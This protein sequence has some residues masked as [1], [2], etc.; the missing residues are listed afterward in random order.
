MNIYKDRVRIQ[1][2]TST[3]GATG[4][5]EIWRP[6]ET[7]YALVIPL[8]AKARSVYMQMKSEVSHRVIFRGSVS[9]SLGANRFIW[10]DKTLQ[11]VEPAKAV[12]N[13]TLVMVKED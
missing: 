6:V 10:K 8:D 4:E 5:T 3:L 13:S 2:K 7:R 9:L 12:G 1:I 11:L